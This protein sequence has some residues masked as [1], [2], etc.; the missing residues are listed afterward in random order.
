[1]IAGNGSYGF[2][3][4]D[5]DAKLA[6][7][8]YPQGVAVAGD[9][10]YIADSSNSRIR[11]VDLGSGVITTVANRYAQHIAMSGGE[12]Y[13]ASNHQIFKMDSSSG[14]LTLVAGNGSHSFSG[15]GGQATQASLYYP[16]D[17]AVDGNQL[18]I[19]DSS[20]SRIRRVDLSSGVITPLCQ[21]S[22]RLT[23]NV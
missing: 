19:A 14:A 1:V 8:Y 11:R 6:S 4:D 23:A 5:G 16:R 3:G 20:N 9:Q 13:V 17:V 12:L 2:S 22:C 18:Y 15:D 7:L 10:L 21:D